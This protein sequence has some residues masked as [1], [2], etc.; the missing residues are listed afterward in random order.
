MSSKTDAVASLF[1]TNRKFEITNLF[2]LLAGGIIIKILFYGQGP[3]N[4]TIWGYSLSALA[5]FLLLTISIAFSNF[6]DNPLKQ[7]ENVVVK[8][9]LPPIILL[10]LLVWTISMNISNFKK[11]NSGL[12]PEEFGVYSF[13][14]SFLIIIQSISLYRFYNEQYKLQYNTKSRVSNIEEIIKSTDNQGIMYILT[15]LNLIILGMMQIVLEFFTTD[16]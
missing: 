7:V 15:I 12:L 2:A 16:G 11:I 3:A 14:S 9:G 8:Y 4:A 10:I 6:K 1:S 5:V 13:I